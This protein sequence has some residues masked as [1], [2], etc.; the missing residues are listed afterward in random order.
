MEPINRVDPSGLAD[1]EVTVYERMR[2][3]GGWSGGDK[4]GANFMWESGLG[5]YGLLGG[6]APSF[7]PLALLDKAKSFMPKVMDRVKK[8]LRENSECRELFGNDAS[9]AGAFNPETVLDALY[10][11]PGFAFP[12]TTSVGGVQ[13]SSAFSFLTGGG[14]A[15]VWPNLVVGTNNG[16]PSVSIEYRVDINIS[17]WNYNADWNDVRT[18]A[19]VLLHEMGHIFDLLSRAGSGGSQILDDRFSSSMSERNT[20]LVLDKCKL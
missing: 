3:S 18:A 9:R 13:V 17:L 1:F 16:W 10:S 8:A 14:D 7:D 12:T 6:S 20:I 4:D 19:A 11:N 15:V 5:E 2:S